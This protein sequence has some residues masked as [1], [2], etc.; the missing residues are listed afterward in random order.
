LIGGIFGIGLA[1]EVGVLAA[2]G[3]AAAHFATKKKEK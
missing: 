1:V 2:G 3:G